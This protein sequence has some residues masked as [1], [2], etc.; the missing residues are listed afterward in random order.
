[1]AFGFILLLLQGIAKLIQDIRT[2]KEIH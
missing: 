2:L 1:M